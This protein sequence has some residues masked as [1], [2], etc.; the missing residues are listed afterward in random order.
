MLDGSGGNCTIAFA[1]GEGITILLVVDVGV[2]AGAG[3]PLNA[4]A[5]ADRCTGSISKAASVG[6]GVAETFCA[7]R[8][9]TR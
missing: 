2:V 5:G 9:S 6:E 4:E 7:G 1:N 8:L 3:A